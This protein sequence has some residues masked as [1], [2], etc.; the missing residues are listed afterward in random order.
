[1]NEVHRHRPAAI[2]CRAGRAVTLAAALLAARFAPAGPA[3]AQAPGASGSLWGARPSAAEFYGIRLNEAELEAKYDRLG[4]RHDSRMRTDRDAGLITI[5]AD[6]PRP[7][8][9]EVAREAPAVGFVIIQGL[10]PWYLENTEAVSN[11]P[12]A[13]SAGFGIW[14]GFGDVTRGPNGCFY[15]ALGNHLYHG[16]KSHVIEYNPATGRHRI[17]LDAQRVVG[18]RTEK[19]TATS[20]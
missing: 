20:T 13:A 2:R 12:M 6:S 19:S 15:F 4:I 8:D 17:A 11:R 14:S 7:V 5:P 18:G 3:F 9:F 1:M 10:E 16:S